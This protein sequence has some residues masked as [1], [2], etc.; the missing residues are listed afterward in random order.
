MA[1]VV[2][3]YFWWSGLDK[4]SSSLC[5]CRA[6]HHHAA[7]MLRWL[8][9]MRSYFSPPCNFYYEKMLQN[10]SVGT[11]TL[12]NYKNCSKFTNKF[13]WHHNWQNK[14]AIYTKIEVCCMWFASPVSA[15]STWKPKDD[16]S[17]LVMSFVITINTMN[18][19]TTVYWQKF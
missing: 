8:H 2:R 5:Q 11:F 7:K 12:S 19:Q 10:S 16:Q 17:E 14:A 1:V 6:L 15:N 9:H 13:H 4:T 18:L 3:S